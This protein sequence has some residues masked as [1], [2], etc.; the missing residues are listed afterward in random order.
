MCGAVTTLYRPNSIST[1][2]AL[3]QRGALAKKCFCVCRQS[4]AGRDQD[5]RNAYQSPHRRKTFSRLLRFI[6][7]DDGVLSGIGGGAGKLSGLEKFGSDFLWVILLS[8]GCRGLDTAPVFSFMATPKS[9]CPGLGS[10]EVTAAL[11]PVLARK[12]ILDESKLLLFAFATPD[13]LELFVSAR[14]TLPPFSSAYWRSRRSISPRIVDPFVARF[15]SWIEAN[16]RT[17]RSAGTPID[18]H[19]KF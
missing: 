14:F 4:R 1:C 13:F 17:P 5:N 12:L 11:P 8:T 6:R 7:D 9:D 2:N 16:L 18:S 3:A 10:G 15:S 19:M